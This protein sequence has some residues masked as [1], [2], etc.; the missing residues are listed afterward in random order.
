MRS[1]LLVTLFVSCAM[2]LS[3]CG[4]LAHQVR[5]ARNI[6]TAPFRAELDVRFIDGIPELERGIGFRAFA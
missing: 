4:L 6:L 3:S 2:S 5:N 1:I